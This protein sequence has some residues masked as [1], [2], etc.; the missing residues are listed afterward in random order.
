MAI[1][2]NV[3]ID[4]QEWDL[5]LSL[6]NHRLISLI[7]CQKYCFVHPSTFNHI[8]ENYVSLVEPMIESVVVGLLSPV[9]STL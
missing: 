3:N 9:F 8:A 2:E 7:L 4:P 1:Y 5:H 6:C